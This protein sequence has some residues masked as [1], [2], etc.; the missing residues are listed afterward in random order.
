MRASLILLVL[1][2]AA[3]APVFAAAPRSPAVAAP[4]GARCLPLAGA[5]EILED[6]SGDLAVEAVAAPD[7]VGWRPDPDATMHFPPTPPVVWGR[8]TVGPGE[9]SW[10]TVRTWGTHLQLWAAAPADDPRG[11]QLV[12]EIRPDRFDSYNLTSWLPLDLDPAAPRTF[13]IRAQS[14]WHL[15]LDL[16]VCSDA[17]AIRADQ[18]RTL[19]L[20]LGAGVLLMM[21]VLNLALFLW[22]RDRTSLYFALFELSATAYL[23][24]GSILPVVLPS[25]WIPGISAFV[26]GNL[27]V[28]STAFARSFLLTARF[29]PW[30]DRFLRGY[31]VAALILVVLMPFLPGTALYGFSL[32]L[33]WAAPLAAVLPG[34]LLWRRFRPARLYLPA[35]G[36]FGTAAL[37]QTVTGSRLELHTLDVFLVGA[38]LNAVLVSLAGVDRMRT[39]REERRRLREEMARA[40]EERREVERRMMRADR[41][42]ALGVVVA[43][44]AHEINNPNNF[45]HFNLP[46]LRKYL[47]AMTPSLE[48]A[49]A[50]DPDLRLLGLS[51]PE[52]REDLDRL[53]DDM[54]HGTRRI[55]A[56]VAALRNHSRLDDVVTRRPGTLR[57]VVD[58]VATL[59]GR[60]VG[61]MVRRFEVDVPEGLPPIAM[62][63]GRIEQALINLVVNAGQA[64]D[65]PDAWIRLSARPG[66]DGTTVQVRV[67]DNGTGIAPEILP[68][69]FDPFFTTK[70]RESGTGLGLGIVERIV[71]E[72]EGRITVDSTVGLGTCFTVELP[73][74]RAT[75]PGDPRPEPDERRGP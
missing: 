47:E 63:T 67:E 36:L 54:E 38:V 40:E 12:R 55:S 27:V 68:R 32:A 23:V 26:V 8:F 6:P 5:L 65:K 41:M 72:H 24:N 58:R 71:A 62:D 51:W 66:P 33:G 56:I 10:L 35:W 69:I 45:I 25:H 4:D 16:A 34:I 70:G 19:R 28:W 46:I 22:V 11:W 64:A 43:G 75:S 52:F 29:L 50:A 44:V 15:I 60:Q 17:G 59:V 74:A 3:P 30:L 1:A 9:R 13:L 7:R 20:G 48:Q 2:F 61:R 31:L 37:L 18:T 14:A 21:A 42:A 57:P 49:A 39:L 73:V 53:I